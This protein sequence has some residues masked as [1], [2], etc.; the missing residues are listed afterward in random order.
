MAVDVE[1]RRGMIS[2]AEAIAR[3]GLSDTTWC[4]V[5]RT[6]A[7]R[8]EKT[9]HQGEPWLLDPTDCERYARRVQERQA[10]Q[11][12]GP[13]LYAEDRAAGRIPRR[14]FGAFAVFVRLVAVGY[15][16]PRGQ[17]SGGATVVNAAARLR[18]VE[19]EA[20]AEAIRAA[21]G[22]TREYL[23]KGES[24]KWVQTW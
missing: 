23:R 6:G 12:D 5:A 19:T 18:V 11:H 4:R 8:A 10:E 2:V 17:Y 20:E 14:L 3:Y 16:F 22:E 24:G 15:E 13:V 9:T 21:S 1:A 7:V